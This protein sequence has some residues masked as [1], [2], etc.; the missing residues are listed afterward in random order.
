MGLVVSGGFRSNTAGKAWRK[1]S[2]SVPQQHV[3][4]LPSWRLG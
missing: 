4:G 3:V 1:S 2:P